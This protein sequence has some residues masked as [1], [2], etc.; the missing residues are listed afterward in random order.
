MAPRPIVSPLSATRY[1]VQ[2]T[3]EAE[4]YDELRLAQDLLRREI[5]TGDPGAI[6]SRALKLL[7]A[8]VVKE[9]TAATAAPRPAPPSA[10]GSRHIPASVKR[11]VWLRDRGQCAFVARSGRRCGEHAFLELHHIQPFAMGGE[12]TVD[13]ISLRCRRHNV[14]EAELAFGRY[15]PR[16]EGMR[17]RPEQAKGPAE[18]R[19]A[20]RIGSA[21][22]VTARGLRRPDGDGR[23]SS[24]RG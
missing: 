8:Q 21:V 13:N 12:A 24:A 15:E 19:A 6:F 23:R 22:R 3:V 4:T 20:A 9:K 5:P 18:V 16:P 10:P 7:L 17:E 11:A 2:F 14:Y 1:R